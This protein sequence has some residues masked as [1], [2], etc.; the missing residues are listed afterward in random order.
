MLHYTSRERLGGDFI[1]N[2]K[3]REERLKHNKTIDE[4]AD[5][6]GINKVSYY[7]YETGTRT[8]PANVV[9]QISKKLN[10][11]EEEFFLPSRYSIRKLNK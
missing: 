2:N 3:L 4:F 9:K 1:I 6:L 7:Q 10:K 8:I 11:K 5:M